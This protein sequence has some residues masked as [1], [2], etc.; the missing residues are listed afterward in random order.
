MFFYGA[1]LLTRHT[2]TSSVISQV[3]ATCTTPAPAHWLTQSRIMKT[4]FQ[5]LFCFN[6]FRTLCVGSKTSIP[7]KLNYF[8][9]LKKKECGWE[10]KF[11]IEKMK[12]VGVLVKKTTFKFVHSFR[13]CT[14]PKKV[15]RGDRVVI[16]WR[17]GR[18]RK[19]P[20]LTNLAPSIHPTQHR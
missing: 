2:L 8:I 14:W 3:K 10:T 4:Y 19:L 7:Q 18:K 17:R 20:F 1:T 9:F 15:L 16:W 6:F 5:N 11:K 13:L 12:R